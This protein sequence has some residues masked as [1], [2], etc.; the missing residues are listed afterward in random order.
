MDDEK[1]DLSVCKLRV[2][3][4]R[5]S[6][7]QARGERLALR[8]AACLAQRRDARECRGRRGWR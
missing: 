5:V 8:L 7:R 3:G 6:A 1:L 4:A 2:L